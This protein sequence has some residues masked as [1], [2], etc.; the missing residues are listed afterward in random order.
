MLE[1][2]GRRNQFFQGQRIDKEEKPILFI[3]QHNATGDLKQVHK[4]NTLE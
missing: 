2:Q 3:C 4:L 1:S